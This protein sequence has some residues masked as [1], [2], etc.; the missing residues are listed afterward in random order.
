MQCNP[1]SERRVL[2]DQNNEL[3]DSTTLTAK[4]NRL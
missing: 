4:A 2:A 3:R 1:R